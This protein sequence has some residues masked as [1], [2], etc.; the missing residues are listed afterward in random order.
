[1]LDITDA[2]NAYRAK[3]QTLVAAVRPVIPEE[4]EEVEAPVWQVKLTCPEFTCPS[5]IQPSNAALSVITLSHSSAGG[6]TA[7]IVESMW[8]A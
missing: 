2:I 7:E 1:M 4:M 5:L 8:K 3:R 6:T